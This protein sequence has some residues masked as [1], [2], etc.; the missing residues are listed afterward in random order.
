ME[1]REEVR[2]SLNTIGGL[3]EV[4]FQ[5]SALPGADAAVRGLIES[6][7]A[8]LPREAGR[9]ERLL[10]LRDPED[11]PAEG[12]AEPKASDAAP[13]PRSANEAEMQAILARLSPAG[14][15]CLRAHGQALQRAANA[16][17]AVK[18]LQE[19]APAPYVLVDELDELLA[20]LVLLES[21][22]KGADLDGALQ[23]TDEG[24]QLGID[25]IRLRVERLR[26]KVA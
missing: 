13:P 20:R 9:L 15:A 3:G 26:V 24:L 1:N 16:E 5:V 8:C 22:V 17:A 25:D 11:A 2:A 19:A 7:S 12:A 18:V 14:V 10:G 23:R 6:V 4:L 21:A